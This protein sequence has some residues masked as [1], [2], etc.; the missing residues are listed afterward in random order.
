MRRKARENAIKYIFENL[1]N[2]CE[3]ELTYENLKE[4]ISEEN[5]VFYATIIEGV[6]DKFDF[7]KQTVSSYISTYAMDRIYKLDLAI[8]CVA[9]YEILFT[10]IP[11]K[12]SVNE[13]IEIAKVYSTDKSPTFI[14]GILA[15][16][17]KNKAELIENY[18]SENNW[19]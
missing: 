17:I 12:V 5:Q 6:K 3:N 11:E 1:V 10:D 18:E 15:S 8:M 19:W 7:I 2:G 4:E 14:N 16:V 9:S 13:A